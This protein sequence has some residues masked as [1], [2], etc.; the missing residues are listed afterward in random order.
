MMAPHWLDEVIERAMKSGKP[1]DVA[2]A[3]ATSDK[4]MAAIKHGMAHKP[5]PGT[6]G[7]TPAQAIRSEVV[8][9]VTAQT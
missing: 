4:M 1:E 6:I 2:R 3:I 9:A 7:P 5:K 8:E